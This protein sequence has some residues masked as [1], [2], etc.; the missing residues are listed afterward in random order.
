MPC[1]R[2]LKDCGVGNDEIEDLQIGFA[3]CDQH[4]LARLFSHKGAHIE[5][6]AR[7]VRL[8][9]SEPRSSNSYTQP[10]NVLVIPINLVDGKCVGFIY[11]DPESSSRCRLTPDNG[12]FCRESLS[13]VIEISIVLKKLGVSL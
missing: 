6:A 3:P 10:A 4:R 12:L 1:R 5:E 13:P 8:I 7:R 11:C 2:V 9:V